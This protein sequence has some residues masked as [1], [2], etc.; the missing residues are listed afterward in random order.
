[1]SKT[2]EAAFQKKKKKKFGGV[3]KTRSDYPQ[4]YVLLTS[5]IESKN[6]AELISFIWGRPNSSV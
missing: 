5:H 6:I 2:Y 3:F 1:M 4:R